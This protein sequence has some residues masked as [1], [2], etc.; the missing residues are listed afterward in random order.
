MVS[1]FAAVP[2]SLRLGLQVG[3]E[4]VQQGS[5]PEPA[6]FGDDVPGAAAVGA[7]GQDDPFFQ[8]AEGLQLPDAGAAH[9]LQQG[10]PAGHQE[11]AHRRAVEQAGHQVPD[12][13]GDP[14]PHLLQPAAQARGVVRGEAVAPGVV[15]VQEDAGVC[16]QQRLDAGAVRF[17]LRGVPVAGFQ[18]LARRQPQPGKAGLFGGVQLGHRD[19]VDA[20][21]DHQQPGVQPGFGGL[22]LPTL[23]SRRDELP[24][25]ASLYL[26]SLNAELGKQIIGFDPR[27]SEQLLQYE[28]PNNYTQFKQVLQEL[29]TLTDSA[30]IRGSVVAE[31]LARERR[32]YHSDPAAAPAAPGAASGTLDEIILQA[33]HQTLDAVGG[34]QTAAAKRLGI[35]RTTLWRY[36]NPQKAAQPK[37]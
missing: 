23:R 16:L 2:V 32:T 8:L 3:G 4:I 1:A 31:V 36:L 15:A 27:A 11:G 20:A 13:G 12:A 5:L 21:A 24:S 29:V 22:Q 19:G 7:P 10:A 17:A 9:H 37:K 33:I 25:L 34:N 26:S 28:W 30:Y 18:L 35:S 14:Y 6:R